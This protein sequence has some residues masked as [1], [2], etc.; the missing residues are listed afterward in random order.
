MAGRGA[1]VAEGQQVWQGGACVAGVCV[2]DA[3]PLSSYYEIRLM[4]GRTH[5]TGMHSC[6]GGNGS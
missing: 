2:W 6:F 3:R 5:P 4:S 1:C